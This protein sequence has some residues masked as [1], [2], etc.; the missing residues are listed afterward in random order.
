MALILAESFL[1]TNHI[2]SGLLKNYKLIKGRAHDQFF[3]KQS[4]RAY[5]S[6]PWT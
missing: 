5:S 3:L 1:G 6:V 4:C 2:E